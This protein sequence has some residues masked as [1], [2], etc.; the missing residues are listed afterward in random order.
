MIP[1]KDFILKRDSVCHAVYGTFDIPHRDHTKLLEN[2]D[3]RKTVFVNN[4]DETVKCLRK[5]FPKYARSIHRVASL[6]E[7]KTRLSSYRAHKLFCEGSEFKTTYSSLY[8]Q[9]ASGTY[10]AFDL[11]ECYTLARKSQNLKRLSLSMAK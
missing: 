6:E 4:T 5:L 7:A 9:A 3:F 1:F 8:E 11:P 10:T 2:A